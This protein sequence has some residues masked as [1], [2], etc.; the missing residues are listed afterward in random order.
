MSLLWLTIAVSAAATWCS[1]SALISGRNLFGAQITSPGYWF[2][3]LASSAAC[4]VMALVALTLLYR[5]KRN[6]GAR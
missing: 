1:L 2:A 5:K 4:L 6:P 3:V